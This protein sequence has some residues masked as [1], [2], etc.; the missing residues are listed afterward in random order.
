MPKRTSSLPL[1]N[2]NDAPEMKQ[3]I[4]MLEKLGVAFRRPTRWQLKVGRISFYPQK[5]TIF[6]DDDTQALPEGGLEALR[7]LLP[8][9][10]K[11]P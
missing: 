5:G 3:A 7:R 1:I 8:G 11:H 4:D 9:G 6:I 2:P 10:D